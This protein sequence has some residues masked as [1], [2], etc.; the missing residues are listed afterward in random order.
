MAKYGISMRD[1]KAMQARQQGVCAICRQNPGKPLCVDHCHET[2]TV[3]GLLCFQ[4]NTGLGC[5]R[6]HPSLTRAATAY[7]EASQG[8]EQT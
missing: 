2:R 6:D 4:C 5:F 7:L 3:R 1:Y 8:E